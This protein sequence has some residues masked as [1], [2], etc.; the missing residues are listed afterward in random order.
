MFYPKHLSISVIRNAAGEGDDTMPASSAI[1]RSA[2]RSRSGWIGWHHD[3]LTGLPR[4]LPVDGPAGAGEP[5][6]PRA[7]GQKF[8]LL[9]LDLDHFK[10]VKRHAGAQ[11][12]R[13][14]AAHWWS[15]PT[16][17]ACSRYGGAARRR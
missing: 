6:T 13:R 17:R 14:T 10:R 8:G 4:P 1:S 7:R 15:A 9:Y 16:L 2:R 11:C 3:T 5:N 12:R